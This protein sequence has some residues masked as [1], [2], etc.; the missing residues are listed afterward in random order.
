MLQGQEHNQY[1]DPQQ[2]LSN[3]NVGTGGSTAEP[4]QLTPTRQTPPHATQVQRHPM[5]MQMPQLP[6]A[7][8]PQPQPINE[9]QI[10]RTYR[11]SGVCNNP[12]CI[13][14]HPPVGVGMPPYGM[15][16]MPTTTSPSHHG[17]SRMNY[18]YDPAVQPPLD[19][20]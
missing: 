3:T 18:P 20:T 13:Y 2:L 17:T 9:M 7:M 15:P 6:T 14:E 8:P 12:S 5:L 19:C 4:Q 10:C 11:F 1:V 16:V